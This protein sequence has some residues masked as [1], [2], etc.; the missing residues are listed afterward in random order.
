MHPL[1]GIIPT[2]LFA[3]SLVALGILCKISE[4]TAS[5]YTIPYVPLFYLPH[6]RSNS[7]FLYLTQIRIEPYSMLGHVVVGA[8]SLAGVLGV[9]T[10]E[11]KDLIRSY[12]QKRN[13]SD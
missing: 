9:W 10:I 3:I 8:L 13:K 7:F 12:L 6:C 5:H 1:R 2:K 11:N 4:V